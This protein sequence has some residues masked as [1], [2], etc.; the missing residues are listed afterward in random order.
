MDQK[1]EILIK[2]LAKLQPYRNLAE[3]ISALV[4]SSYMDDQA[5][6]WLL[7]LF[8]QSIKKIQGKKEKEKLETA[9]KVVKKL[10]TKEA[11][12]KDK[13]SEEAEEL[14]RTI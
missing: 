9:I 6:D 14:L 2:L 13:E 12:E 11:K 4:K 3:G 8:A 10:K 5:L 7:V 1:K